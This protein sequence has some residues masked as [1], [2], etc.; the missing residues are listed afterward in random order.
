[1]SSIDWPHRGVDLLE[2]ERRLGVERRRRPPER[3]REDDQE[4]QPEAPLV[5]QQEGR[6]PAVRLRRGDGR[7]FAGSRRR[8]RFGGRRGPVR[9]AV[10][11]DS[12]HAGSKAGGDSRRRQVARRRATS[13]V[14]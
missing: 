5:A 9:T 13:T 3:E 10:Q 11:R 14:R 1:L 7:S 8:R 4:Q 6:A 12:F 2:R